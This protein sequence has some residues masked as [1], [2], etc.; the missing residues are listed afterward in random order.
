[1][2]SEAIACPGFK[3]TASLLDEEII[4]ALRDDTVR[5]IQSRVAAGVLAYDVS[6]MAPS[7][8]R[9]GYPLGEM[10]RWGMTHHRAGAYARE[11]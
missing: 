10:R 5:A 8:F 9:S 1:M 2:M 4:D 3:V 6:V 7:P 11:A